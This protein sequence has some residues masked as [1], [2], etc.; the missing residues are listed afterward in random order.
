M[1]SIFNIASVLDNSRD[2]TTVIAWQNNNAL[3]LR[4]FRNSVLG[5]ICQCTWNSN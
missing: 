5:L 2:P 1:N 3:T 4:E